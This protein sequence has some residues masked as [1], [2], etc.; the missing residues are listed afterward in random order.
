MQEHIRHSTVPCMIRKK[1]RKLKSDVWHIREEYLHEKYTDEN[2]TRD[3]K[4]CIQESLHICSIQEFFCE[5]HRL[6]VIICVEAKYNLIQT[7]IE[8][9]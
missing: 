5:I 3:T 1:F 7:R 9:E 4:M 2:E 8:R 6:Y